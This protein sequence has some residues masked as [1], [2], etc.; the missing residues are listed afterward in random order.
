IGEDGN[1]FAVVAR[2]SRA[3]KQA[4]MGERAK[5]MQTRVLASDS[6]LEALAIILEYV[7]DEET[8]LGGEDEEALE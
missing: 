5:E 3:L 6:Y 7:Q 2:A 1:I 8:G 4:G